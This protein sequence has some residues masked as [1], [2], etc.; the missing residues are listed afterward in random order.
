MKS[1]QLSSKAAKFVTNKISWE[2]SLTERAGGHLSGSPESSSCHSQVIHLRGSAYRASSCCRGRLKPTGRRSMI[3]ACKVGGGARAEGEVSGGLLP[4]CCEFSERSPTAVALEAG[5]AGLSPH[6]NLICLKSVF[7][8]R[9]PLFF[10]S[11]RSIFP[12]MGG[13]NKYKTILEKN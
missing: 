2:R 8:T 11:G 5:G 7:I 4:S 13:K 1:D 9:S 6:G 3:T 10:F 12:P